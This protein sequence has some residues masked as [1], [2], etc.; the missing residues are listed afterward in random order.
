MSYTLRGRLESRLAA[1]ALPLAAA[2][3]LAGALGTWWPVEL[4]GLM[5]GVAFAADLIYHPALAYQPGW[6]ALPLGVVELGAT[7]GLMR[8]LGVGA[9][10]PAA[11]GFYAAA[12]TWS[13]LL[14]HA[15]LPLARRE[16]SEDGGELGRA[17]AVLAAGFVLPFVASGGIWWHN[18][19]PT[20]RLSA[21]IHRGP[22]YIDRRERLIGTHGA[23]VLGGIVVRHSDVTISHVTVVGGENGITIDDVH[24]VV[25]RHVT[26]RGAELDGIH[27]R[28]A[29]VA[30]HDCEIDMRGRPYGQGIDISFAYDRGMSMVEG[31]KIVGGQEGIVTHS[32]MSMLEHND[33]RATTLRGITVTEMSMGE[34]E[35][36]SVQGALGVG[37]LCGDRSMCTIRH[38][39]VAG[40]RTDP[41]AGGALRAG[42]GVEIWFDSQATLED[43]EL[44]GNGRRLGVFQSSVVSPKD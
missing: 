19:P 6:A 15:V 11:L 2:L 33:V 35:H 37:V 7:L 39:L 12:W 21:G 41:S 32:S 34:V 22:L 36:N 28:R 17:G 23:V 25:L 8:A 9:P 38:N 4:C 29:A 26:V 42:I 31:C 43:N 30:I 10:L 3:V 5:A 27:V 13:Q 20:V 14:A 24:N 1:L 44:G 40:T 18:L 16:W